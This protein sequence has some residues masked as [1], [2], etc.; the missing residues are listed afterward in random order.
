HR[1]PAHPPAPPRRHGFH[2]MVHSVC[3][4]TAGRAR[5]A[6]AAGSSAPATAMA[7]AARDS[8]ASLDGGNTWVKLAGMPVWAVPAMA[9][10]VALFS[11]IA[12]GGALRPGPPPRPRGP[13]TPHRHRR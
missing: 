11:A 13:P 8:S 2:L 5:A 6:H 4:A 10:T 9:R 7:T 3:R 1:S 12:A